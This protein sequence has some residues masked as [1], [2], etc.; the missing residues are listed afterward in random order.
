M[1]L[2][3]GSAVWIYCLD[4]LNGSG[5]WIRWDL[6]QMCPTEISSVGPFLGPLGSMFFKRGF[7]FPLPPRDSPQF[8]HQFSSGLVHASALDVIRSI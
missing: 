2:L 3:D 6:S 1:D 5:K 4:P 7:P 8:Y